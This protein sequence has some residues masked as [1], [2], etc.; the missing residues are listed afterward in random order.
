MKK[1]LLVLVL[2][3]S[4][5]SIAFDRLLS[6]AD[7]WLLYFLAYKAA[8]LSRIFISSLTVFQNDNASCS[9]ILLAQDTC[10]EA[11]EIPRKVFIWALRKTDTI[12]G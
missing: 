3:G 12:D 8:F 6:A 9:G 4:L 5:G 1:L 2:F 10:P 11:I 7:S